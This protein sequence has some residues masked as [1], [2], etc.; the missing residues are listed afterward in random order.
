MRSVALV[1]ELIT[2]RTSLLKNLKR[3]AGKVALIFI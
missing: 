2:N 1:T 3:P